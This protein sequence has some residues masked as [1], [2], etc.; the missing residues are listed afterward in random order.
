MLSTK[1][2]FLVAFQK[3]SDQLF[4]KTIES[5]YCILM[6]FNSIMYVFAGFIKKKKKKKTRPAY[7]LKCPHLQEFFS[8]NP[9]EWRVGVRLLNFK[10]SKCSR[11]K[12]LQDVRSGDILVYLVL[13]FNFLLLVHEIWAKA[14]YTSHVS[15][16][17]LKC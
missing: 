14:V 12:V 3:S 6:K 5:F 1:D 9:T 13:R 2:I 17:L 16:K 15:L 11:R 8:V 4:Y 10:I 7:G